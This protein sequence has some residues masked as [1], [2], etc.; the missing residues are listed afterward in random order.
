MSVIAIEQPKDGLRPD[1]DRL[2]QMHVERRFN[3]SRGQNLWHLYSAFKSELSQIC[4]W[5]APAAIY[6]QMMFDRA[7]KRY[8]ELVGI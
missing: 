7:I 2:I 5:D 4:G 8:V 1:V 3:A 6:D